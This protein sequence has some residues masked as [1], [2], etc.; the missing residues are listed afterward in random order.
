MGTLIIQGRLVESVY[1]MSVQKTY[2]DKARKNETVDLW[3][4][5]L[6]LVS[7]HKLKILMMKL[8]FRELPQLDA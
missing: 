8:M 2:V 3:H 7:Y 5:K 6:G 4:A 1:V